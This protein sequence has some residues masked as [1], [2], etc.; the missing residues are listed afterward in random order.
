[1]ADIRQADSLLGLD[2]I[3]SLALGLSA[4]KALPSK[5]ESFDPAAF[6]RDSLQRAIQQ[7]TCQEGPCAEAQR[8][9]LDM[10][11]KTGRWAQYRKQLHRIFSIPAVRIDALAAL[12]D[13][14]EKGSG[15]GVSRPA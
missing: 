4:I 15:K 7:P 14:A 3:Q 2:R 5:Q 6:W 11:K 8:I 1:M 9:W 13:V 10:E 12:T